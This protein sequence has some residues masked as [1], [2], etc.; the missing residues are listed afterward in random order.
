MVIDNKREFD[1]SRARSMGINSNV[2]LNE[3]GWKGGVFTTQEQEQ[4]P[5][6]RVFCRGSITPKRGVPIAAR[7]GIGGGIALTCGLIYN[8]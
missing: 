5:L 4:K 6:R 3:Q 1:D 7:A 8:S 2:V